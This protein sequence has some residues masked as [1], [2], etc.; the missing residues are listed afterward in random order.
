V[1]QA[2]QEITHDFPDPHSPEV[3]AMKFQ[4]ASVITVQVGLISF[5]LG[6][7]RLG[8]LDVVLSR[9]LLRGFVS[10]LAVVITM[11]ALLQTL[12]SFS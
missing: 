9:A 6:V 12:P 10:A 2:I 11:C 1:G 5:L 8:F 3:D 7:F 4:I